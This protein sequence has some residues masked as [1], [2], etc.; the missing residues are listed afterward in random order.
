MYIE[1]VILSS[2]RCLFN[3]SIPF[4]SLPEYRVS[5]LITTLAVC[6]LF[7]APTV[8]AQECVAHQPN[9]TFTGPDS[10][11]LDSSK[12]IFEERFDD[13]ADFVIPE[14]DAS[15]LRSLRP[16]CSLLPQ[17]WTQFLSSERWFPD[18][19]ATDVNPSLQISNEQFR[20][21]GGKS[22]IIWDESYGGP[23]TW[24]SDAV[25]ARELGQDIKDVYAEFYVL[26]QPGY[27]WHHIERGSGTNLAKLFRLTHFDGG[28]GNPFKFFSSGDSAPLFLLDLNIWTFT[29]NSG[30]VDNRTGLSSA[31]RCDPQGS[32]YRCD[33]YTENELSRL[34]GDPSF[35]ES[36]GD[37]AWH[38]IGVRVA[39][40]SS[41]GVH[42][43]IITIWVDDLLV[44]HRDDVPFLGACAP[45]EYGWNMV[46]LGGN[47]HN[48]PEPEENR[49]EQWTAI[50]DFRLYRLD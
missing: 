10:L 34:N 11:N 22:M 4:I 36:F 17:G 41:P 1:T 13:L 32:N 18:A 44:G 38:K 33:N 42:G 9:V 27:R 30:V 25:F 16:E 39:M 20:G 48:Y 3:K 23:S 2:S 5:R 37:G 8:S 15:C 46:M 12:L 28:G 19:G 31:V 43:G 50:D 45:P 49:F 35:V 47:M 26:F 24:G 29:D 6:S 40:N 14:E 21:A 7:V